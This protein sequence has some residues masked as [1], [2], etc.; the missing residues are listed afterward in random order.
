MHKV[1]GIDLGT[2]YSAVSAYDPDQMT[3]VILADEDDRTITP[4]VVG[5]SGGRAIAGWIAKR[6]GLANP[7]DTIVEIKRE[8]GELFTPAT[9]DKYIARGQWTEQ[10]A[11]HVLFNKLWMLPQEISALILM[12]MKAIAERRLGEEIRDAVITVPAYFTSNQKKATED[13]ALLAGLYPRQ[14]IPEPTAAAICYGLDRMDP[15]SHTYLVYDLGG[16][17]FDVSII[18]VKESDV[19]VLATS[20]DHRLGGG[21]FDDAIAHWAVEEAK[22]QGL[23][24][25]NDKVARAMVKFAAEDTKKLLSAS[26]TANL[27]VSDP[28]SNRSIALTLDRATFEGLIGELLKRSLN[29]V[30]LAIQYAEERGVAKSAIDQVLLVGGST[31][32]PKVRQ[33]L[34]DYFNRDEAFVRADGN[35]DLLV[36]RGAALVANNFQPSPPP[37]SIKS[38]PSA[39]LVNPEAQGVMNVELITEHTLGVG[40]QEDRF[41][42]VIDRGSPIPTTK[43]KPYTN[44]EGASNVKVPIFQGE[45]AYVQ[46]NTLIGE[47][48]IGPMQPLPRD[49]HHFEVTFSLD[50]NGLL[51]VTV[52]HV[53][54]GKVY[55]ADFRH[56]TTV[57]G[58]DALNTLRQRLLGIFE[59]SPTAA[60]TAVVPPPPP[61]PPPPG[62][63][64]AAAAGVAPGVAPGPAAP[65]PP[66]PP[67]A[68]APP[69]AD[70]AGAAAGDGL[71]EG[72][73]TPL[74]GEVKDEYRGILRRS[75]KQLVRKI[76]P[77]LV[78]AYNVF[79]RAVNANKPAD[80][81][82]D[83]ADE[84][85]DA[86]DDAR[87]SS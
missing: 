46:E 60:A 8:M 76:D 34:L 48:T 27:V 65:P 77:D 21:D 18:R 11:V 42:S 36:A 35:P 23:D 53:N 32:V 17:T 62:A 31:R 10:Q 79:A 85:G 16:G 33:L 66:P 25:S 51:T 71:P 44:P 58:D 22:K 72:L 2:T 49:S 81:V 64:V 55:K 41:D 14:L 78:E 12:R 13:A 29:S 69:A 19:Q 56:E 84:L 87:R 6:N 24:I 9:L 61:P 3:S 59:A 83:L 37:F 70:G 39:S 40:V 5:L 47:L 26:N 73:L 28:V 54:E 75:R 1:I 74:T 45:G 63:S 30:A 82:Q 7:R 68:P 50:Q 15:D 67:S 20:G 4:S 86:Y 43:T 80:V 52:N 38:K 57:K